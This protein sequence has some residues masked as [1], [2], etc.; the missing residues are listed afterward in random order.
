M[1]LLDKP[2][3]HSCTGAAGVNAAG[4]EAKGVGL[5]PGGLTGGK[6]AEKVTA[7]EERVN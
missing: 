6:G 3:P 4:I 5:T 2:K 1:R 7:C